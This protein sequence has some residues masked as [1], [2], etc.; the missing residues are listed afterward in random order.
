MTEQDETVSNLITDLRS[1]ESVFIALGNHKR[2]E[3]LIHLLSVKASTHLC[4]KDLA[5]LTQLSRPAVSHHLKILK[6]AGIVAVQKK[7]TQ[8]Y[9][10]LANIPNTIALITKLTTDLKRLDCQTNQ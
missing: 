6:D 2:I 5:T 7:G 4:V 9:Y 10:F 1:L 8:S 3:L